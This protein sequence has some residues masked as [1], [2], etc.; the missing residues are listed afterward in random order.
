MEYR[1]FLA[2]IDVL[3]I[4]LN[5]L[6]MFTMWIIGFVCLFDALIKIMKRKK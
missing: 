2:E 4:L 5:P 1:T 3:G 6:A